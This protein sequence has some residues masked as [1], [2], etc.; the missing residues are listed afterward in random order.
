M[1]DRSGT[2]SFS[3]RTNPLAADRNPCTRTRET[4]EFGN[5]TVFHRD[6]SF[7]PVFVAIDHKILVRPGAVNTDPSAD[8]GIGRDLSSFF[9]L[10]EFVVALLRRVINGHPAAPFIV[11]PFTGD[12]EIALGCIS[13][14]L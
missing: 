9:P 3:E 2:F 11:H 12:L 5:I 6:T 10:V 4:V 7:R 14:T 1:A 8:T 13:V